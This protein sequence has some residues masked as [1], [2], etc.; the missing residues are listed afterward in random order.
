MPVTGS[1]SKQTGNL[2]ADL[3]KATLLQLPRLQT[4]EED[5]WAGRNLQ[6]RAKAGRHGNGRREEGRPHGNEPT[7]PSARK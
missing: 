1:G 5:S 4:L 7:R 3:S 6:T 2:H